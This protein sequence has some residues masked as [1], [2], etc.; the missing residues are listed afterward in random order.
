M[1]RAGWWRNLLL[2]KRMSLLLISMFISEDEDNNELENN[3]Q[4]DRHLASDGEKYIISL[5]EAT[6]GKSTARRKS[7]MR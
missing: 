7:T 6:A 3:S 5:E 1:E 4:F 2:P